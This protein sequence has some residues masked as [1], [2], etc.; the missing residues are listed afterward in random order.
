MSQRQRR[1]FLAE[2]RQTLE[3][4]GVRPGAAIVVALSGGADSVALL[5]AL[6]ELRESGGF[7]L[8]AAHLNHA[9]RGDESD[10]DQRF[11]DELCARLKLEFVVE[12]ATE[13]SPQMSNLEEAARQARHEFLNRAAVQTASDY[14]ALG[15]HADDQAE[16]VLMRLL[17]GAGVAG[18]SAMAETGPGRLIRPLLSLSRGDI[19]SYL[20][21]I[22]APFVTD[23]SNFSS[24]LLRNRIRHDLLPTLNRE[25]APGTSKRLAALAAEMQSV[26]SFLSRAADR[27]L[28]EMVAAG[29]ELDLSRFAQV[30]P[31]LR[32]SV[33]RRYL[34]THLGSLRRV[35][36]DHL[37]GLSH[38]CLDGPANG[39]IS[40]P[41]GRRAVRQYDRLRIADR[42]Q[43]VRA[44]FSTPLSFE[45]TTEI[46]EAGL[47]FEASL[48]GA[49]E[50]AMPSDHSAAL[51]DVQAIAADGLTA[52][53]F[54]PGDRI[55]PLGMAG[56]RKV[57]DVFIDKKLPLVVRGRFPVVA[58]GARIVWL[59]G[60]LRGD[61]ALVS[62][63]SRTVLQIRARQLGSPD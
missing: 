31:A 18:L 46:A 51:F 20:E 4:V 36:R 1:A 61:G 35:N 55:R 44:N 54:K 3:R 27:E 25:Y 21:E 6:L 12:K 43:A 57:K 42:A 37:E 48:V 58:M 56:T 33:L 26:D 2:V 30:D 40:L 10:C 15:H 50:V 17:R 53:N 16:T 23:A 52:R 8:T 19:L 34:A 38:L 29:G 41:G 14:V 59:P 39:E 62:T 28:S 7:R 49:G 13:L 24:A 11:C 5:H 60:I 32:L 47:A 9:L 63:A 22:G 45:G